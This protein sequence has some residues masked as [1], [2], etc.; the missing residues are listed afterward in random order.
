MVEH[1]K[2]V[3][4][5][6]YC[7]VEVTV[8]DPSAVTGH[9]IADLRSADIDW[10]TEEDDLETAVEELRLDLATSLA[11]VADISRICDDIPGVEFRGG[12]CWAEPG[13]AR[14]PFR[15]EDR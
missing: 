9:A 14:D 6:L 3:T 8:T 11:G 2:P 5:H 13:P 7:R 4:M 1:S 12:L 15:V 10:S